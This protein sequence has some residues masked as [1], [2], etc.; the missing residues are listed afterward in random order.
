MKNASVFRVSALFLVL[1]LLGKGIS[2]DGGTNEVA[3]S[4]ENTDCEENLQRPLHISIETWRW[5]PHSYAIIGMNM[6]LTLRKMQLR[7]DANIRVSF[8]DAAPLY[9]EVIDWRSKKDY[10]LFSEENSRLLSAIPQTHSLPY[11]DSTIPDVVFKIAYPFNT[12]I[13]VNYSHP[14][15]IE[16]PLIFT[17]GTVEKKHCP[18]DML[19]NDS[20]PWPDVQVRMIT[21]SAWSAAG[22]EACGVPSEKID[23]VPNGYDPD[24]FYAPS[25]FERRNAYVFAQLHSCRCVAV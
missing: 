16:R 12:S 25:T 22:L 7:G 15:I 19:T 9:N 21:P 14:Q 23:V 17:Y 5:L 6:A 13:G 10:G 8:V 18:P 4:T 11:A 2:G 20:P 1:C 3:I 24:V